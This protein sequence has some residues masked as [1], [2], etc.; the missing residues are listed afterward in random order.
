MR[1]QPT[2]R[3]T[4]E[5]IFQ[6]DLHLCTPSAEVIDEFT[7]TEAVP[8]E[9]TEGLMTYLIDKLIGN[10]G[11]I[12]NSVGAIED[13][14]DAESMLNELSELKLALY[15]FNVECDNATALLKSMQAQPREFVALVA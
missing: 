9:A 6:F 4:M 13:S 10:A 12:S 2:S 3:T 11:N 5:E 8:A 7:E 15:E 14:K 1:G